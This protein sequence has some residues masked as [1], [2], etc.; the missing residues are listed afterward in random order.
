MRKKSAVNQRAA[1][2]RNIKQNKRKAAKKAHKDFLW[3]TFRKYGSLK[4][5][6]RQLPG[7]KY[8]NDILEADKKNA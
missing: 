7:E 1:K 3:K 4:L 8:W 5:K 6:Q 2:K